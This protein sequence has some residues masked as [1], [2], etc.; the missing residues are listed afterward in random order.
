[1][2][3]AQYQTETPLLRRY[4]TIS[5]STMCLSTVEWLM[6]TA[7]PLS[8]FPASVASVSF[9]MAS[10]LF[11]RLRACGKI[12]H[13]APIDLGVGIWFGKTLL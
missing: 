1:M 8:V 9:V 11:S 2:Q 5:S 7:E 13:S 12:P 3:S 10:A 6:N 4:P